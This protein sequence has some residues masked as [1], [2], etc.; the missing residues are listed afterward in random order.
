MAFGE[1]PQQQKSQHHLRAQEGHVCHRRFHGFLICISMKLSMVQSP[2]AHRCSRQS[3][4]RCHN[5]EQSDEPQ[6]GIGYRRFSYL[7]FQSMQMGSQLS[8]ST[9]K[10][11]R[12]FCNSIS[13]AH[14]DQ[15]FVWCTSKRAEDSVKVSSRLTVFTFTSITC[16]NDLPPNLWVNNCIP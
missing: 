16:R 15:L 5:R 11:S 14:Q 8:S 12:N 1:E 2:L 10:V 7:D 4:A 6:G 9:N 13:V 3:Y